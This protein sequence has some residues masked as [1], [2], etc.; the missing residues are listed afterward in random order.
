MANE[1]DQ[2][3]ISQL[4]DFNRSVETLTGIVEKSIDSTDNLVGSQDRFGKKMDAFTEVINGP[5]QKVNQSVSKP[6]TNNILGAFQEG[7]I[8]KDKGKYL[9]GENGPELVDLPKGSAVIP[10]NIKDFI[11]GISKIPELSDIAKENEIGL[12]ADSNDPSL[13]P[14]EISDVKNRVSL[15]KLEEKYNLDLKDQESLDRDKQNKELIDQLKGQSDLLKELKSIT[16]K[17]IS[18]SI[19]G[20]KSEKESILKNYSDDD[21]K[22]YNELVVKIIQS[23]PKE[24]LNSLSIAKANLIAA[25]KIEEQKKGSPKEQ[26]ASFEELAKKSSEVVGE[27]INPKETIASFDKQGK[28]KSPE[29][30]E[31][32]NAPIDQKTDLKSIENNPILKSAEQ[33]IPKS[34]PKEEISNV[35]KSQEKFLSKELGL[36]RESKPKEYERIKKI[37]ENNL[38]GGAP[39]LKLESD[40][41]EVIQNK[42][43][44]DI[45]SG[46]IS[47]AEIIKKIDELPSRSL[48]NKT[49]EFQRD[50]ASLIP[51]TIIDSLSPDIKSTVVQSPDLL[52]IPDQASKNVLD[53]TN[54]EEIQPQIKSF[55]NKV[56]EKIPEL[57]EVVNG[58]PLSDKLAKSEKFISQII[59]GD[60]DKKDS[61]KKSIISTDIP[62]LIKTAEKIFVDSYKS[63]GVKEIKEP[64]VINKKDELSLNKINPKVDLNQPE[65]SN[66]KISNADKA[67]KLAKS[68][69][70]LINPNILK[71][72]EP[73]IKDRDLSKSL[74]S[75]SESIISE[76]QNPPVDRKFKD[77][78]YENVSKVLNNQDIGELIKELDS[79]KNT[80]LSKATSTLIPV[81]DASNIINPPQDSLIDTL[82]NPN[83]TD[84]RLIRNIENLISPSNISKGSIKKIEDLKNDESAE[85]TA[86]SKKT[87]ESE[88]ISVAENL[89]SPSVELFYKNQK[90]IE[91]AKGGNILGAFRTGGI[92]DEGGKYLV[93]ENGPE[94]V[95]SPLSTTPVSS[96]TQE[97]SKLV[98]NTEVL[99]A[100]NV[101]NSV[102]TIPQSTIQ[103][104]TA[105]YTPTP[106]V[107]NK[108]TSTNLTKN[109]SNIIGGE[110]PIPTVSAKDI[111]QQ[112]ASP[113]EVIKSI[114]NI[115][116]GTQ[117]SPAN[118]L[119][120]GNISQP[121]F[122]SGTIDLNSP[123]ANPLNSEDN[124]TGSQAIAQSAEMSNSL[125]KINEPI[126]PEFKQSITPLNEIKSKELPSVNES[127]DKFKDGLS[128]IFK[129]NQSSDKNTTVQ[130]TAQPGEI[131]QGD[132]ST[133]M[134]SGDSTSTNQDN[135]SKNLNENLND[136]KSLLA[137]IAMLLE[138]PL[139]VSTIDTPFRP[140]SRKF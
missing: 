92:A 133:S 89:I 20:V 117:I 96:N 72:L 12:Y 69:S 62:D 63:E 121:N 27:K 39:V 112:V 66:D 84:V 104:N 101:I 61:S 114:S 51:K 16:Q 5:I 64:E 139:E 50:V 10:L 37:S 119:P 131:K 78:L 107:V 55:L 100:S 49:P 7:G 127:L 21:N 38:K 124:L 14:L 52:S 6:P 17:K 87:S 24:S 111:T 68:A 19:E 94:I 23:I 18:D 58:E 13:L 118:P 42:N 22:R 54:K 113:V 128:D 77:P 90:E 103:N 88:L 85:L 71:N 73:N 115:I 9:V 57:N 102:P 83:T 40:K 65:T 76:I 110:N 60:L 59:N 91:S 32:I 45:L 105:T 129:Q 15:S 31:L 130:S 99:P 29:I 86:G 35:T 1:I 48:I 132:K 126:V 53:Q 135:A 34:P 136:V 79:P 67:E 138:G 116:N 43:Y 80:E 28:N 108:T 97:L 93:G 74:N 106:P 82:N 11:E 137:R 3:V 75:I 4:L 8:A 109:I 26:V 25:K 95:S 123:G 70:N 134:Q 36:L 98:S 81:N 2:K 33:I 47:T 120:S 30:E 56:S 44:K 125:K 41:D 46:K 122:I 140:D